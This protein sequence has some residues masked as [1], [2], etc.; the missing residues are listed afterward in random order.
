MTAHGVVVTGAESG[1]GAPCARAFGEASD[2]VG[3]PHDTPV[4]LANRQALV[5]NIALSY[6]RRHS[7]KVAPPVRGPGFAEAAHIAVARIAIDCEVSLIQTLD[8]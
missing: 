4:D 3:V 6:V 8:A 2:R 7:T 5:Q 1:I